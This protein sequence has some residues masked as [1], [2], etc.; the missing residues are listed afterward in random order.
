MHIFLY[1]KYKFLLALR[2]FLH[3]KNILNRN[4]NIYLIIYI[5]T[6]IFYKTK[7]IYTIQIIKTKKEKKVF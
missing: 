2:Q 6:Q 4:K 7:I 3:Y 1:N 5:K